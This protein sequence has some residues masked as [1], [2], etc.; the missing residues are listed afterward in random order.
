MVERAVIMSQGDLITPDHVVFSHSPAMGSAA[1]AID[2][3]TAV[4]RGQPLP[5]LIASVER[6]AIQF[7]LREA[8]G[9]HAQAARML[10]ISEPD[11]GKKMKALEIQG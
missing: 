11:L 2:I 1:G 8:G 9:E 10:G 6:R 4:R 5:E 7:G 3:E